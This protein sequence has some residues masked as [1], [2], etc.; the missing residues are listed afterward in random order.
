MLQEAV[1]D[2]RILG[3]LEA[4]DD[5]GP[6]ALGG[7][8][9]RALLALLLMRAGEVVGTERLVTDLWG[10]RP[11]KTATT[12]LQ[13]FVSQLRKLLGPGTLETKAP[14]YVLRVDPERFD[15]GGPSPGA[16]PSGLAR[17]PFLWEYLGQ[18][19]AMEF[20]GGFVGVSQEQATW[21]LRP[22]IGWVIREQVTS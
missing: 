11:P 4:V 13:N 5:D 7:Q 12:S 22:E 9:Q 16:F 1:I 18:K 8:K 10:E 20:L 19:H 2:F 17:A 21:A 15:L 6:V 14:G 3:P